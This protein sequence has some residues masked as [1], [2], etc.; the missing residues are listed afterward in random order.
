MCAG[1]DAI[2]EFDD[3]EQQEQVGAGADQTSEKKL[4]RWKFRQRFKVSE[5]DY[6]EHEQEILVSEDNLQ[7]YT[8]L[9]K[10]YLSWRR[11][12]L[13][14]G[15]FDAKKQLQFKNKK[16]KWRPYN[17][18]DD[19][20]PDV[21]MEFKSKIIVE[22]KAKG[23]FE[24]IPISQRAT[25]STA[26]EEEEEKE[27]EETSDVY[28]VNDAIQEEQSPQV[29]VRKGPWLQ[30]VE[31]LNQFLY[32]SQR[33]VRRRRFGSKTGKDIFNKYFGGAQARSLSDITKIRE[34]LIVDGWA[35]HLDTWLDVRDT[36]N[37]T[38]ASKDA[39]RNFRKE[40]RQQIR[41][42]TFWPAVRRAWILDNVMIPDQLE[43]SFTAAAVRKAA[44]LKRYNTMRFSYSYL[45]SLYGKWSRDDA[46]IQ[47]KWM[48]VM[49]AVGCRK[50]AVI[51]DR[52][53]FKEPTAFDVTATNPSKW[54]IQQGV[55]KD[56]FKRDLAVS[57][58]SNKWVLKP[59]L[60]E[61]EQ[62]PAAAV[63]K[64]INDIRTK[65]AD[66][67]TRAQANAVR[68]RESEEQQ[69]G[70]I[71]T[72][73]V[74]EVITKDIISQISP[75]AAKAYKTR[76]SH[77]LR[78]IYAVTAYNLFMDDI[79]MDQAKFIA[80][81]LGHSNTGAASAYTHVAIE[82]G[83]NGKGMNTNLTVGQ[84]K[85]E[86]ARISDKID[87]HVKNTNHKN[88]RKR[89]AQEQLMRTEDTSE[90]AYVASLTKEAGRTGFFVN[91]TWFELNTRKLAR[92]DSQKAAKEQR[93]TTLIESM[94]EEGVPVSTENLKA[95]G[96]SPS[97]EPMKSILQ[98]LVPSGVTD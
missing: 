36:L 41:K 79:H 95:V 13:V 7:A 20:K 42:Q 82:W 62:N 43:E 40:I 49:M 51:F 2:L 71:M 14:H 75:E 94:L 97:H 63:I 38:L 45:R 72:T 88:K 28:E 74:A 11:Q 73:Q 27:E 67:I 5:Q 29:V 58:D 55:L 25:T 44:D 30:R 84:M 93:L 89:E 53:K 50:T 86:L 64:R 6:Y 34:Q 81:V 9:K 15:P 92:T 66:K 31:N 4:N 16:I 61:D 77:I 17:P 3:F 91:D 26:E 70:R 68:T 35:L 22:N 57:R 87:A 19:P 18:D 69:L 54:I 21:R 1:D 33:N 12:P 83:F 65:L 47:Q 76:K 24:T 46:P 85:E 96:V 90:F 98:R 52:I 10:L 48:S 56:K 80:E 8:S 60:F 59:V 78:A 23:I 39:R 37:W 32:A